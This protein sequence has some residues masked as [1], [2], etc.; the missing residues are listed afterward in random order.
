MMG[1]YQVLFFERLG[2]KY[3]Y[4]LYLLPLGE[5]EKNAQITTESNL[6]K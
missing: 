6:I 3:P 5:N 4:L 2:L 1:D